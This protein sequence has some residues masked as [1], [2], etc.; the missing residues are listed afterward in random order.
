MNWFIFARI[1]TTFSWN[2][3][4]W[5]VQ[6]YVHLVDLVE[7]FPTSIWSQKSASIQPRTSL[8]KFEENE[9]IIQSTPQAPRGARRLFRGRPA[10]GARP[11]RGPAAPRRQTPTLDGSFSAVWTSTI[12]S[13]DAFFCIFHNLKDLHPFAPIK[14]FVD[15]FW[16]FAKFQQNFAKIRENPEIFA[17]KIAKILQMLRLQ[18]C[19]RMQ[20]L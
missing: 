11:S 10:R 19:K 3:K 17:K 15:F 1:M 12:A 20:I 8:S 16:N 2:F 14:K 9:Y 7:S 6:K 5:A 4:I 18:R 13:K